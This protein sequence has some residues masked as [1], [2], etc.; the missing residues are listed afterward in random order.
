MTEQDHTYAIDISHWWDG[1]VAQ[2]PGV[3]PAGA[4]QGHRG[5]LYGRS[6]PGSHVEG[7]WGLARLSGVYHFLPH[8]IG[9]RRVP[10]KAQAEYFLQQTRQYWDDLNL[11]ANDFERGPYL[12][13]G[14][15]IL[16]SAPGQ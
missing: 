16:Q 8:Q 7:R 10:P 5:R 6:Q 1:R 13:V 9:G 12:P 14:G 4:D 2:D 3:C 15:E 11:R